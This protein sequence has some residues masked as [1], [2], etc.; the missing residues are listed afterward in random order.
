MRSARRRA[1]QSGFTLLEVLVAVTVLGLL[2]IGLSQGVRTGFAFW[3][4]QSR[5]SGE[6]AEL[7]ATARVLR[8]LLTGIPVP[9]AAVP[10]TGQVSSGTSFEGRADRLTFVGDLPTGFGD[11]RRADITIELRSGRLVLDWTAHRHELSSVPPPVPA[12]AELTRGV[13][14]LEFA[15]WG[16]PSG[17]GAAAW[18]AQWDGPGLPKLI[19]VR[20]SFLKGDGRRWPDLVAAPQLWNPGS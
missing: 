10:G 12:E 14:G 11:N 20:L 5:R 13:D 8:S 6:T 2:M 15:Y 19:R 17:T 18:V 16:D 4:A 3:A 7:D 9:P 1:R